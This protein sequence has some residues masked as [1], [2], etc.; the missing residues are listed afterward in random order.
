MFLG[1]MNG[2]LTQTRAGMDA[3]FEFLGNMFQHMFGFMFGGPH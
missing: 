2:V 1:F 3:V